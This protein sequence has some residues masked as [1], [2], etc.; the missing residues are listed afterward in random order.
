MLERRLINALKLMKIEIASDQVLLVS[1]DGVVHVPFSLYLNERYLNLHTKV[2]AAR[3]LRL[4]VRLVDAF[5][6]DV[7]ARALAGQCLTEKEKKALRQLAFRPIEQIEAMSDRAVRFIASTRRKTDSDAQGVAANT[8]V[9]QLVQ[10]ADFLTWYF[11]KV[12]EPRMPIASELTSTLRRSY[13]TCAQEIKRSVGGTKS[14]HAHLVRSLPVQRY[15]DIYAE[16]FLRITHLLQTVDQRTPRNALRDR[17]VVLLAAEGL[18]PGAIGNVALGDFRWAGE[19]HSG[20]IRIQD[21]T[22]RR[23]ARLTTGTP[24]QKGSRSGRNYS[25]EFLLSIWPTTA[26]AIYDYIHADRSSAVGKALRNK[27]QGFLFTTEDGG[28]IGDRSTISAIFRRVG[29]GLKNVGL[30]ARSPDDPYLREEQYHF[31]AYVLRH[32][33]ASFFYASKSKEMRGPVVEDLMK[34]RF[35]W[36]ANSL[37]PNLYAQRAMSDAASLSVES[38]VESLLVQARA[39]KPETEGKETQ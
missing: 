13:Q 17:A 22:A 25:S 27:S 4:L 19:N 26:R 36:S 1:S 37:M 20:H 3:A 9:K 5:E 29:A 12:L 34:T 23:A 28:P 18:R 2:A 32:S 16:V 33:A 11:E 39:G 15:L 38:F 8:A 35:G 24:T 31:T 6:V 7:V 14:A 30:L 21:N 10:I